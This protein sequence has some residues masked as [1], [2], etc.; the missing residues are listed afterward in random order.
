MHRT[1][2][3]EIN[4]VHSFYLCIRS[5]DQK[6]IIFLKQYKHDFARQNRAEMI[7]LQLK[8]VG[9]LRLHKFFL[10]QVESEMKYVFTSFLVQLFEDNRYCSSLL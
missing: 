7:F 8:Y 1:T 4:R 10:V 6:P 5:K 3:E 2:R 9:S